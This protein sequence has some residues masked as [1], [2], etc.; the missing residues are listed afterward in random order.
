[1]PIYDQLSLTGTELK[2]LD[3]FLDARLKNLCLDDYDNAGAMVE[4]QVAYELLQLQ[5]QALRKD[6][7]SF[8]SGL[9]CNVRVAIQRNNYILTNKIYSAEFNLANLDLHKEMLK[10]EVSKRDP[11]QDPRGSPRP[12]GRRFM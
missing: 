5:A 3:T 10:T 12:L 9:E 11:V 2:Q 8:K 7:I 4:A 6:L 1:M